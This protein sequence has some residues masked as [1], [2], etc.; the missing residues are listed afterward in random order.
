MSEKITFNGV[1]KLIII[2]NGITELN[3][4]IDVYSVWKNWIFLQNNSK[5]QEAIRVVGGDPISDTKSLGSTFFMTNGWR[6]RP[7]EGNHKLVI[8]GN[9]FTD[10]AGESVIVPT[11]GN[12]NVVV[13]MSV[14]NISDITFVQSGGS[15]P[16]DFWAT[17]LPGNYT[18]DQ[19]GAIMGAGQPMT[20]EQY[21][22]LQ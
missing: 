17:E 16:E 14:S 19:A 2:E 4:N 21:V 7:Y 11:V 15:S 3:F 10:P 22:L 6:I 8:N 18:G 1:S 13:E 20:V 12:Y 9:V 5:F